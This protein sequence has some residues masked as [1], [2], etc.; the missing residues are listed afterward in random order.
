MVVAPLKTKDK[1]IGVLEA[2]NKRKGIFDKKDLNF[3]MTLAP[4]IAMAL[5]NARMYNELDRSYKELK[6]IGKSKDDLIKQTK[7]EVAFLRREVERQHRFDQV[8]GKSERM[9]E[10][11]RLCERIIDSDITVLIEGE[12]GTGKEIIAR[13]IHYN[14]PRK[15]RPFVSQNCAGIPDTLLASELFGHKK[16]AYTGAFKDKKG[17]FE[18]A[19]G[20]TVFLDEAAEM[21]AAMQTS[22]LRVLQDG[23]IKPLGSEL[24]KQ[25]NIRLI[26]ATNQNLDEEVR[27]GRLREDLFYRLSVFTI[28]LPPLRE[29]VADIPILANHFVRKFNKKTKRSIRGLNQEAMDCLTAYPFPG[30]V[31][32]LENEIE[33]AMAMAEDGK[34]I[35]VPDLSEK[36]CR[37]ITKRPGFKLQG[38]LKEMVEALEKSVLSRTLEK[39]GGNKTRVAK[40][41]G[42]SRYGLIKKMKRY[43]L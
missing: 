23:E 30:N 12:T 29:R 11:L 38:S 42:L 21:S 37:S 26:S 34:F 10:V 32:E 8:I 9:M 27:E 24:S 5:D 17:L 36:T 39:H 40:E 22:L 33:R 3:F 43:S 28:K 7:N 41:L 15:D 14:G 16:G 19:H 18:I 4:I 1:T 31:R 20:G 2:L 25:V 6:L 13:T 35:E